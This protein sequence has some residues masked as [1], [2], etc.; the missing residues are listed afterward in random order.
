M[1]EQT[2][3]HPPED[4]EFTRDPSIDNY[5]MP[6]KDNLTDLVMSLY[7]EYEND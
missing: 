7:Q 4:F 1:N 3:E 5:R 2:Q 6:Y